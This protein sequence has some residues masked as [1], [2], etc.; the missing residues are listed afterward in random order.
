MCVLHQKVSFTPSVVKDQGLLAA[1]LMSG[2]TVH[3]SGQLACMPEARLPLHAEAALHA[4]LAVPARHI[5][6]L[7]AN[8]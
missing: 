1:A 4:G 3:A 8:P 2:V 5:I 7:L 6:L